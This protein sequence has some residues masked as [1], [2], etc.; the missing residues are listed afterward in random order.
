MNRKR[1]TQ[2]LV[3]V[4]A[5]LW[6]YNIYRTVENYQVRQDNIEMQENQPSGFVPMMFNKDTFDLVLPGQDPFMRD[7]STY[8]KNQNLAQNHSQPV[9]QNQN[10]PSVVRQPKIEP[11]TKWPEIAYY[12]FV[13]NHNKSEKLCL[14][15]IGNELLR[16]A[17]NETK[18]QVHLLAAYPDSIRVEFAGDKRSFR[19]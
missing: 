13:R 8:R 9:Q 15:K 2:I 11:S 7:G 14:V 4:V 12:G 3:V 6:G 5:G 10:R 18:S 19:K 1:I 17:E 16:I